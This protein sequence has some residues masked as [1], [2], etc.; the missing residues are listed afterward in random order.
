MS[1]LHLLFM[2]QIFSSTTSPW[3][4]H[5]GFVGTFD[6]S[7]GSPSP[8]DALGTMEFSAEAAGGYHFLHHDTLLSPYKKY[9]ISGDIQ[10]RAGNLTKVKLMLRDGVEVGASTTTKGAWESFSVEFTN[11]EHKELRLYALQGTDGSV[12]EYGGSSQ[13]DFYVR[14]LVVAEIREF[15][16]P[17]YFARSELCNE[18]PSMVTKPGNVSVKVSRVT[19]DGIDNGINFQTENAQDVSINFSLAREPF[20][21]VGYKMYR[22]K[23]TRFPLEAELSLGVLTNEIPTGS[24][25]DN[26]KDQYNI[27]VESKG[28]QSSTVS[29]VYFIWGPI[30]V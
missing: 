19:D 22:E 15:I 8:V 26:A 10:I 1:R 28:Q 3:Q 13:D 2:N 16:I 24:F 23:P 29:D 21:S 14:N 17:D 18:D 4:A 5:V 27:V 25:T 12:W 11:R 20:N 30:G 6:D 7:E 9:K